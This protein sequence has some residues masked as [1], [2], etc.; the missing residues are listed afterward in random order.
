[1]ES[2]IIFE[3]I[4]PDRTLF[5]QKIYEAILPAKDG[6]IA[7]LP[8]H[9]P[10]VTILRPGIVSLRL[11]STDQDDQ[12]EHVV[13][14]GGFAEVTGNRVR[15]LADAAERADEIDELRARQ[16]MERADQL[17]HQVADEIALADA[18]AALERSLARLK[19]TELKKRRHSHSG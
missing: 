16:A 9:I 3:L 18:T 2:G 10:L 11:K 12:L 8:N 14:S 17:K 15:I 19:L 5:S 1:M 7:I 6:Q 13:V 4:T